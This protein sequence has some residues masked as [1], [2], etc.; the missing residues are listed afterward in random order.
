VLVATGADLAVALSVLTLVVVCASFMGLASGL[1]AAVAS[2]LAGNY[3]FTAPY[4]TFAIRRGDDLV[5]LIV[6]V[7]IAMVVGAVAGRLNVLRAR[8]AASEREA[9]VRVAFVDDLVAGTEPDV[10]LDAL[11]CELV[12]LFDLASVTIT[13]ESVVGR[14]TG[15]TVRRTTSVIETGPVRVELVLGRRLDTGE[16]RTIEALTASLAS[17][18]EA[19]R[20]DAESRD[21]EVRAEIDRS[22]AAFLTATT[23]DLQTPIAAIKAGI[24]VLLRAGPRLSDVDREKTLR[25]AYEEVNRLENRV[26]KVLQVTRIRAGAL[27]P[28]AVPVGMTDVVGRAVPAAP[29]EQGG[30]DVVVDIGPEIPPVCADPMMLEHIVANLVENALR[31]APPPPPV[32]VTAAR[33][34]DRVELRVI[35][36]GPGIPEAD[37]DCV[38]E[39][40]VRLDVA[41][42][43]TGLGLAIVRAFVAANKGRVWYECTPNGGATFVVSFPIAPEGREP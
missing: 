37:R 15:A 24:G 1:V 41:G 42:S 17:A 33:R 5:A 11:A 10:A 2:F 18:L 14:A 12:E 43:G 36:H 26:S 20:L 27:R 38:F 8:A 30:T 34:A 39:E 23:H 6:G 31:Y 32:T 35:D 16:V 19:R 28:N 9:M 21:N 29:E 13:S 40:F 22:R 3:Y 4:H 7:S 25:V